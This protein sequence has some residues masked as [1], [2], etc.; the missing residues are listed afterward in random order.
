MSDNTNADTHETPELSDEILWLLNSSSSSEQCTYRSGND[1]LKDYSNGLNSI[2]G[3]SSDSKSNVFSIGV[4]NKSNHIKSIETIYSYYQMRN[5]MICKESPDE[6]ENILS[7]IFGDKKY[8]QFDISKVDY[9]YV[10][11][12]YPNSETEDN[13]VINI[14]IY[15]KGQKYIVQFQKNWVHDIVFDKI[16]QNATTHYRRLTINKTDNDSD[17]DSD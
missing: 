10:V 5:I 16:F 4:S 13:M 7:H 11:T 17:S 8:V 3:D 6:I 2:L 1:I 9:N 14:N 12:V 15:R